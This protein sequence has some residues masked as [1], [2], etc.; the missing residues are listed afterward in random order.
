LF[1]T[2]LDRRTVDPKALA[3]FFTLY[4][5]SARNCIRLAADELYVSE[6]ESYI[7]GALNKIADLDNAV[8]SLQLMLDLGDD[9]PSFLFP[10]IQCENRLPIVTIASRHIAQ[11]VYETLRRT[12]DIKYWKLYNS[13]RALSPTTSA[14]GWLWEARVIA[15]LCS[16]SVKRVLKARALPAK[17]EASGGNSLGQHLLKKPRL[18][19]SSVSFSLPFHGPIS[20]GS[21]IELEKDGHL[22][23]PPASNNPTFNALLKCGDVVTLFQATISSEHSVNA[24]GLNVIWK[25]LKGNFYEKK[26]YTDYQWQ[27]VF[28]VPSDVEPKWKLPQPITLDSNKRAWSNL[29]QYVV[30]LPVG[31]S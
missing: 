6:W 28:V 26:K 19:K 30:S 25:K 10:I 7:P 22:Y 4:S 31:L 3:K 20:F 24:K 15:E 18:E 11:L 21:S 5:A 17:P 2:K 16:D 1:R 29:S 23:T 12:E 9:I 27:L 8:H 13:F 14:A